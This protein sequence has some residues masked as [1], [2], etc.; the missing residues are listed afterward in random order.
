MNK[1]I[2]IDRDGVLNEDPGFLHRLEDLRFYPG[3][4]EALTRLAKTDY[5]IIIVTNQAGIGRGI[6][7]EEEY[8]SFEKAYLRTLADL[9]ANQ[10][11]IDKVYFCPHHPDKGLG[12]Y[13]QHCACRKPE[14]GMLLQARRDYDLD[15]SL[16]VMIGDKRSDIQ[17]GQAAGCRT[18][19]VETGCGGRG[20]G[21]CSVKPDLEAEDL[22]V[23]I[24]LIIQRFN[25]V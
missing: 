17:A 18:I 10:I 24:D 11:R 5:K 9:S 16:C 12:K 21:G 7:T 2:F 25:T 22:L 4:V 15:L 8:L 14:P 3:V 13:K 19:L 23:A 1:A 6:F 20:G